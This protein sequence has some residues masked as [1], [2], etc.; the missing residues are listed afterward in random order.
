MIKEM[1]MTLTNLKGMELQEA[2]EVVSEI[3]DRT[4][5]IRNKSEEFHDLENELKEQYSAI[6]EWL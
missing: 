2:F 6:Q 1:R 3:L 5:N 4:K